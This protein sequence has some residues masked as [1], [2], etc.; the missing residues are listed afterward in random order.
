MSRLI[1]VS[2]RVADLDAPNSASSGG[3][4]SALATALRTEGGV[5]LGW[6][7]KATKTSNSEHQI[8]LIDGITL[9]KI[10]L[11]AQH[12]EEYYD[13]FAN[14]TLWP[15]FHYR[16]DLAAYQQSFRDAYTEVNHVFAQA[17]R[18]LVRPDDFIW[19]HDYHLIPLGREL[20]SMGI[21]N[22]IGFFLHIPWPAREVF[23]TLPQHSELVW[24]MFAYDL[25]GFQSNSSIRAFTDYISSELG[26]VPSSEGF[27]DHFGRAICARCYPIG[28]D[29]Q[30]V[31]SLAR[32]PKGKNAFQ[33]LGEANSKRKLLLGVDRID[34]SKGLPNKFAAFSHLL[35]KHSEL[36]GTISLLQI[37]QP[38]RTRVQEYQNLSE[39]LI[40]EAG[41]INATFGRLDWTPLRYHAQSYRRDELAGI[42]QAA[43]ACL[44]TPLRDGMNLV[45]KEFVAAQNPDD[46]G[47]L[48]LS[49]F[50]GAAEHLRDAL[51]I[52]PHSIDQCVDAM[53][54]AIAMPLEERIHRWNSLN[55]CVEETSINTWM[56]SFLSDLRDYSIP[57]AANHGP[58]IPFPSHYFGIGRTGDDDI[59]IIG[60]DQAPGRSAESTTPARLT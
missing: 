33:K 15:L 42:Y 43:H 58:S 53:R 29:P 23:L 51:I 2:N 44:V 45:A 7:G 8:S 39:K 37:G 3:L 4:A 16:A 30:E 18:D 27:I 52:N 10:D 60:I 6:S 50:A 35:E 22:R 49:Q 5:W 26:A 24:S 25:I 13:G 17:L 38:S 40:A 9:A 59:K 32:S 46:P 19:I 20:R 34:Y 31:R 48:I 14:Q 55:I 54:K 57:S 56:N 1:V 36:W 11:P 41:R 47:V 12:V 28:V 21:N